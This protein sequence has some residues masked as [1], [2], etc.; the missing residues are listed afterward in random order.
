M[1]RVIEE[2]WSLNSGDITAFGATGVTTGPYRFDGTA[3]KWSDIWA[4]QVPT[5]TA[6][7]LKPAHRFSMYL[8]DSGGEASAGVA[9]VRIEIRDQS[10]GDS[11][12][13][14]GPA[15][16]ESVSEFQDR[17]KMASL[18]ITSDFAVEERMWIVVVIYIT[19]DAHDESDSYFKLEAARI[20]SGV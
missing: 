16:Y 19:G 2:A 7:V 8:D 20:R 5:G 11:K 13:V 9:R 14:F 10:Q 6:L 12:V 15:M 1:P 4:Y 18:D 3:G 17:D